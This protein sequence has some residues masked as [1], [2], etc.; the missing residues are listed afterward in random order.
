M[1]L[2]SN[3]LAILLLLT[4]QISLLSHIARWTF[5]E[6]MIKQSLLFLALF[7]NIKF[8]WKTSGKVYYNGSFLIIEIHVEVQALGD[9]FIIAKGAL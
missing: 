7:T 3:S 5:D 2:L 6:K 9:R 4:D 8:A 1:L